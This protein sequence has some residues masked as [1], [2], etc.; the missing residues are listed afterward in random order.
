VFRCRIP[1][2]NLLQGQYTAD[3]WFGDGLSDLDT[4]TECLSFDI[5][6]A[7]VYRSGKIPFAQLGAV[8]FT[9]GWEIEKGPKG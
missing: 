5:V 4:L 2:I 9:P 3:V 8:Y 7:D 6:D 1:R